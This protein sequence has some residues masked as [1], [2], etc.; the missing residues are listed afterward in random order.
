[1]KVEYFLIGY[2]LFIGILGRFSLPFVRRRLEATD[3][4]I[5][6]K[7]ISKMKN[8]IGYSLLLM[9][10]IVTVWS[11]YVERVQHISTDVF[12]MVVSVIIATGVTVASIGMVV[13]KAIRNPPND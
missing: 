12:M 5:Q 1:M 8:L 9:F 10:A 13:K 7:L 3:S 6:R 4:Q 11:I 2:V